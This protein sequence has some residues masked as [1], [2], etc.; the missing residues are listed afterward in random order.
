MIA[1]LGSAARERAMSVYWEVRGRIE[2]AVQ[3]STVPNFIARWGHLVQEGP[4]AGM[5]YLDHTRDPILPKLVGSYEAEIHPWIRVAIKQQYRTLIDVGCA[6]G[7]FAVGM[8][9]AMPDA[10]IYTF[11]SDPQQQAA[12]HMLARMNGVEDRMT[13]LGEFTVSDFNL[14]EPSATLVKMDCEGAEFQFLN[15]SAA[16]GLAQCDILVEI[17]PFIGKPAKELLDRFNSSHSIAVVNR[18]R[19]HA[20]EWPSVQFL[21]PIKRYTSLLEFRWDDNLCWAFLRCK[22]PQ[23]GNSIP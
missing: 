7:Y 13:V 10:R 19:R 15:P 20:K 22:R 14:I 6:E 9:L 21:S 5:H 8:A 18:Q 3:R 17:H 11:D 1:K 16:L 23:E 4:F 2:M 12:C